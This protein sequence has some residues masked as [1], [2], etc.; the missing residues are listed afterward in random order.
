MARAIVKRVWLSSMVEPADLPTVSF[1]QSVRCPSWIVYYGIFT[2]MLYDL[3]RYLR[4]FDQVAHLL[5]AQVSM[6]ISTQSAADDHMRLILITIQIGLTQESLHTPLTEGLGIATPRHS[7]GLVTLVSSVNPEFL[8]ELAFDIIDVGDPVYA[9]GLMFALRVQFLLKEC[10][11]EIDICEVQLRRAVTAL[12]RP[13][14]VQNQCSLRMKQSMLEDNV[15]VQFVLFNLCQCSEHLCN[16]IA[17]KRTEPR[18]GTRLRGGKVGGQVLNP[19]V[20]E[21]W[22]PFLY[23]F[24]TL[25]ELRYREIRDAVQRAFCVYVSLFGIPDTSHEDL[26]T[27]IRWFSDVKI[28]SDILGSAFESLLPHFCDLAVTQT[29]A[30]HA[31][32]ERFLT[33]ADFDSDLTK[34][35]H[36][37]TRD[38]GT[39]LL[40]TNWVLFLHFPAFISRR[41][42]T[43]LDVAR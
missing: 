15:N 38:H 17:A 33:P 40:W 37:I 31:I 26:K 24:L 23:N 28:I 2:S 29:A 8:I 4:H 13:Y 35:A 14:Q 11:R 21:F 16:R 5:I 43:L 36:M 7:F 32:T 42:K 20:V 41:H 30:L 34:L 6:L 22:L 1:R 39:R 19:F 12:G 3:E 25:S 9:F 10:D 27:T 18:R